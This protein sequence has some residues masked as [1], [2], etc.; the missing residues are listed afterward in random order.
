MQ[1][2]LIALAV[3][4]LASTA[5]FAQTNVVVYGI[6]DG[7]LDYVWASGAQRNTFNETGN[8]VTG[9]S[10]V[11]TTTQGANYDGNTRISANS[12]YIGFKG[13]EDLGNG[14]KAI[15]QYELGFDFTNGTSLGGAR[16]SF[17]GLSHANAG[18]VVMGNL[19]GPTRALGATLDVN[20]GAT[21]IGANSAVLGKIA[22]STLKTTTAGTAVITA[23][24][25]GNQLSAKL[26]TSL[27]YDCNT[28]DLGSCTSIFDTRWANAIAYL[29]P[30]WG[31]FSFAVAGVANENKT[32]DYS[33]PTTQIN[34]I[35]SLPTATVQGDYLTQLG[36]QRNTYGYDVGA[37]WE[38]MGFMVGVTYNWAQ[39]GDYLLD[40]QVDNLRVGG[41]YTAGWGSIRAMWEQTQL[42]T[43]SNLLLNNT[44]QQKYG[45][46]GTFNLGKATLL[47]Q[48]YAANDADNMGASGVNFYEVGALYN[49]SKRTMLKATWAMVD[50]DSN[51]AN[52]FGVVPVGQNSYSATATANSA[53]GYSITSVD[54]GFG[55]RIQGVQ[56]GVRHAF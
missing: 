30:T 31:G 9:T 37:K 24:A 35:P 3:A 52:D 50:N 8:L 44:K 13:S 55:S 48:W 46:G 33:I 40:A 5:A 17:V 25:A 56:V 49:L 14:L 28:K 20:P 18:T 22:G 2:K 6:A 47:A 19:T 41:M 39:I 29:S 21:G 1:K 16:D 36:A 10:T 51:S 42:D 27:G 12:S 32:P 26:T 34:G 45:L 23:D 4:G 43:S 53:G 11:T 54:Q 15:F 38:G 7:T